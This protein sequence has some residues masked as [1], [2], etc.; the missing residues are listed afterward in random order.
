MD[1]KRSKLILALVFLCALMCGCVSAGRNEETIETQDSQ[2]GTTAAK[3]VETEESTIETTMA[4]SQL[5]EA[6]P[7][8]EF[9]VPTEAPMQE[10]TTPSEPEKNASEEVS[11]VESTETEPTESSETQLATTEN[12]NYSDFGSAGEE[13]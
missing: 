11:A 1:R 9:P 6:N 13:D 10:T 7:P 2:I 4:T 3:N 8:E 12:V 5:D